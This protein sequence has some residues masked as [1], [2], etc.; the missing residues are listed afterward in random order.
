[1]QPTT[2]K[3]YQ[4]IFLDSVPLLDVRAPIEFGK[5]A[6]PQATNLPLLDD[7]EREMVGICYKDQ[8]QDAAITLGNALVN[9]QTRTTR[10]QAWLAWAQQHPSGCLYCFRGGLRSRTAQAWLL[11][12]GT[13]VPLV[14]GGYKALRRF[15]LDDFEQHIA[16]ASVLLICGRTG[17]GKTRV[18]AARH[19]AIDLEGLA[20]HRGSAFGRRPS[21]QP[22]QI[23]FENRLYIALLRHRIRI[24]STLLLEDESRLIGRCY[25]PGALQTVM[26]RAPRVVIEEP[27]ESRVQVTL[28]DYVTGPLQEYRAYYGTE[29]APAALSQALLQSLEHIRKRLGGERYRTLNESMRHALDHHL[30]SGDPEA[31]RDW[32]R[33]LLSEYY[34]PMY[35][36]QL[37]KRDTPVLFTGTRQEVT[38]WLDH[39][40]RLSGSCQHAEPSRAGKAKP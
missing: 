23:D 34:D 4:R 12:S 40:P 15:L 27:V 28:E 19:S 24:G 38:A 22:S 18:I 14:L 13:N 25:L 39:E 6:F 16:R 7:K 31:H 32:I 29:A 33:T 37:S 2:T 1:M 3:D 20:H 26:R 35:D 36:Y 21:G 17:T 8:G 5:G 11:E 9:G 30:R 10:Q